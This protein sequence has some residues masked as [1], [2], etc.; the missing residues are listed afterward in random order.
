VLALDRVGVTDDFFALGGHSLMA[1]RLVARL[2]EFLGVE[3]PLRALFDH[4]TVAA[5]TEW[6]GEQ[7]AEAG[8]RAANATASREAQEAIEEAYRTVQSL[9]EELRTKLL[10]GW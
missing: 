6:A 2:P 8:G 1:T 7:A 9:P 10:G 3:V 5:L 4:P